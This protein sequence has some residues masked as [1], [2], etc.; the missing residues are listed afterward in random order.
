MTHTPFT[1]APFEGDA[2][3]LPDIRITGAL[4]RR[5]NHLVISWQTTGDLSMLCLP[6]VCQNPRRQDGLWRDTCFEL[7]FGERQR[8][9]YWELNLSP[10]GHWNLYRFDGY[11]QGMREETAVA[12]LYFTR[13]EAPGRR[14]TLSARIPLDGLIAAPSAIQAG[15]SAVIRVNGNHPCYHALVHPAEKPDFHSRDGFIILL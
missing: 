1:L 11:R 5:N 8:T 4:V 2:P 13:E 9:G 14:L 6:P 12:C 15:V 7:F 3:G 10:A